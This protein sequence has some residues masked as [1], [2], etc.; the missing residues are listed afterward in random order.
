MGND[1]LYGVLIIVIIFFLYSRYLESNILTGFWRADA[2]FCNNAELD[3]F[4]LYFGSPNLLL[5]R[6]GY[7]FATN[8]NGIILNNP[9]NFKISGGFTLNPFICKEKK[10]S[11]CIDWN[12]LT[13]EEEA[14][15]SNFSMSYFPNNSKLVLYKDD[16]VLV[17]L[18]K[19]PQMSCISCDSPSDE[20]IPSDIKTQE[21]SEEI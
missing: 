5:N 6:N 1:I 13:P 11:V 4:I 10:Y 16:T 19:D 8:C 9:V 17:V 14:F 18:W 21:Y 3:M 7:L 15:P 20:L 12:D 2:E